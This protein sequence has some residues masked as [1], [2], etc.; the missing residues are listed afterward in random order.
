ML[1]WDEQPYFFLVS[2]SL[3]TA[4]NHHHHSSLST[5]LFVFFWAK[6]LTRK[7]KEKSEKRTQIAILLAKHTVYSRAV[8]F[9]LIFSFFLSLFGGGVV[10][11]FCISVRTPSVL[12]WLVYC[13]IVLIHLIICYCSSKKALC[14][15]YMLDVYHHSVEHLYRISASISRWFKTIFAYF[16]ITQFDFLPHF[17]SFNLWSHIFYLLTLL[18]GAF[19]TRRCAVATGEWC[20]AVWIVVS[21]RCCYHYL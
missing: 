16:S 15:L 21:C 14:I 11:W 17:H 7:L 1:L 20:G 4:H 2:P 5:I 18:R 6:R 13:L 8:T 19:W 9:H 12:L 10:L 3:S